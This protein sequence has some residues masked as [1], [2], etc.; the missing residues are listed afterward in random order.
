MGSLEGGLAQKQGDRK[1]VPCAALGIFDKQWDLGPYEI[2][3]IGII[4]VRNPYLWER[5]FSLSIS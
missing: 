2:R 3:E 4:F 1:E 5:V